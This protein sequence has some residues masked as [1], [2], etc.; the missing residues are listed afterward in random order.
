MRD[1]PAWATARVEI[2]DWDPAWARRAAELAAE[3]AERL[4]PLLA[5]PVEHVGSTA[6]EGLAGKPVIDLMGPVRAL[7]D[8]EDAEGRL[9]TAGWAVVPPH[10]DRR[11]WRRMYVL[12]DGD[13]RAA[14]LHLVVADHPR[15]E[16]VLM[17]RDRLRRWPGLA[18]AY[19]AVKRRA[20]EEHAGD[21]ETYTDAKSA[22]VREALR[23]PRWS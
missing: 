22:F 13:R 20:A 6:V 15:W 19:A 8:A 18:A 5:G 23:D 17:F 11:P 9:G 12:P 10:L 4:S 3:L 14:H 2:V 21:R 1:W 7:A 16:E